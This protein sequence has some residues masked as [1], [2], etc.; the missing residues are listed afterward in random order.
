M[1]SYKKAITL[2]CAILLAA[3]PLTS[4]K[5]NE[6]LLESSADEKKTV[7]TV[8]EYDVPMEMYRYVALNY[9]NDYEN[10][11]TSDIW[12]RESGQELLTELGQAS[13]D[14]IANLYTTLCICADYGINPDDGYITDAVDAKMN[15]IYEGY[16]YDYESYLTDIGAS[17]MN[18]SVYRFLVRNDIMADEL[19]E[20]MKKKGELPSTDEEFEEILSG[21]EFIRVKQILVPRDSGSTDEENLAYAESLLEK[22]RAGEDFD[23]LVQKYGK[24][25]YLFNNK[26]GYYVSRGNYYEEFENAAF[27]LEM[28]EIS[29]IVETGAGY[30]IIKRYP[31]E[32][33]Y[34]AKKFDE[35]KENYIRGQYNIIL[36]K[37]L[38]DIE[39][40]ETDEMKNFSVFNMTMDK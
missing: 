2:F 34:M 40:K 8:G 33:E 24:D 29:G 28:D 25:L 35:L 15:E 3:L 13:R 18:D 10:G 31:K 26:D 17:Y 4:C 38:A 20:A 36:G 7:L 32:P 5:N 23:E 27:S 30:S 21:P 37:R 6:K 1:N 19:I 12:L 11:N 39:V 9:K 22:A 16:D 14:T